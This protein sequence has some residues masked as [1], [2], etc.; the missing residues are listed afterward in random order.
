MTENEQIMKMR[1][2]I[3][4]DTTNSKFDDVFKIKLE[5]AKYIALSTL[6]PF[7]MD[8][9]DLPERYTNWQVRCAIELYRLIGQEGFSSYQENGLSWSKASDYVSSSLMNELVPNVGVPK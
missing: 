4:K 5:D 8:K 7:D 6:Y 2:E 1:L 9:D 3:L